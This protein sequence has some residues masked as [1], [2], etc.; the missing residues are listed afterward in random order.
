MYIKQRTAP[1]TVDIRSNL[2]AIA[3]SRLLPGEFHDFPTLFSTKQQLS[4]DLKSLLYQF[5]AFIKDIF[6]LL[7]PVSFVKSFL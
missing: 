1:I 3:F 7:N 5:I 6:I 4:N 2:P